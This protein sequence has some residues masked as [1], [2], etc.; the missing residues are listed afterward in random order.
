M[1]SQGRLIFSKGQ[2]TQ[3]HPVQYEGKSL[4]TLFLQL[5]TKYPP[6][7]SYAPGSHLNQSCIAGA[8]ENAK[9]WGHVHLPDLTTLP[10][11]LLLLFFFNPIHYSHTEL[12][13]D[14]GF[15]HS[16][17]FSVCDITAVHMLFEYTHS[18]LNTHITK[19][20]S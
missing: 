1:N 20:Y 12:P 8:T 15:S 3:P 19:N 6:Y 11:P 9:T 2:Q 4:R 10:V 18:D 17:L 13:A 7:D 5:Q 16:L 14:F